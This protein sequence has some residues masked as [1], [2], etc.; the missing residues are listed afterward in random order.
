V[1][2]DELATFWTEAEN[3]DGRLIISNSNALHVDAEASL[4]TSFR[5]GEPIAEVANAIIRK[6]G[7]KRQIVGNSAVTSNVNT[8]PAKAFIYRT[9]IG[10]LDGLPLKPCCGN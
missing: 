1:T 4:T 7:E 2:Y 9:N 10:V 6:F 3:A 5:F 8:S